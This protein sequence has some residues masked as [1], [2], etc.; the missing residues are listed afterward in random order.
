MK[1]AI[2]KIMINDIEK[3]VNVEA[4][5]L[6]YGDDCVWFERDKPPG[7]SATWKDEGYCIQPFLHN[8]D[9]TK[10]V[11]TITLGF[12]RTL[13]KQGIDTTGF[14]LANYHNYVND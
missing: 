14:T 7:Y 2:S 13:A 8:T 9:Y 1:H 6:A 12:A 10:L 3:I 4:D 11:D 5:D